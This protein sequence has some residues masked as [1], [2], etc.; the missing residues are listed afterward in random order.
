MK[1]LA[2]LGIA[3]AALIAFR[4]QAQ[5][6]RAAERPLVKPGN[7]FEYADRYQTVA[8]RRWEVTEVGAGGAITMRCGDDVAYFTSDLA[9]LRIV[10]RNGRERVKFTPHSNA[11]PFPLNLGARW[12][13]TF[14]VSTAGALFTPTVEET[15]QATSVE[16]VSVPAGTFSAFR[17][18][19]TDSWSV[20]F[21]S[22]TSSATLWYAPTARTV[23]KTSNSGSDEWNSELTSYSVEQ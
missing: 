18:S 20:G 9:V 14:E 3:L 16:T 1:R 10:G 15:C 17:I 23:V 2:S 6:Y 4:C 12:A 8:C 19:C 7:V 11:I 5:D 21:F 22:G 13:Q